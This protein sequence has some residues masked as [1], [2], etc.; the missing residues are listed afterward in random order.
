ME[1]WVEIPPN[2]SELIL[3]W[4]APE[5]EK[6]RKRWAVG[7]LSNRDG[8]ATF[9]YFV[10][11]E[12]KRLN[13]GRTQSQ[14]AVLG[15]RGYP[16]FELRHGANRTFTEGV[17]E[18][19]LRRVPPSHRSDFSRYLEFYRYRGEALPPMSL[20]GLT[21]AR[22]PSDGFSLIDR[23]NPASEA[24]DLVIEIAGFRHH[25][26]Q[27]GILSDGMPLTLCAEPTNP[28]DVDAV[29]IDAVGTTIG[30]VNWLQAASISTWLQTR[31]L[32]AWLCRRNGRPESPV[33]YAFLRM[34]RDQQA[35]A[36]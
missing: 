10:G 33:A 21:S 34:R 36:A 22:L 23:L 5:S 12:F 28:Y 32:S 20:L 17:M 30:Y 19:F 35:L 18:A 6:D 13:F 29:R 26:P 25:V 27:F 2:P 24:C 8:G 31:V 4:R 14:L 1:L 3:A 7:V 9:R 15:Y 11:E 16:A